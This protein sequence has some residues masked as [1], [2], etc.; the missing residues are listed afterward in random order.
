MFLVTN[1]Y[2]NKVPNIL[3]YSKKEVMDL[4]DILNIRY[5]LEGNGYVTSQSISEGTI[6]SGEDTLVVTLMEKY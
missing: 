1:E 5:N 4:L 3:G 2:D 6:M